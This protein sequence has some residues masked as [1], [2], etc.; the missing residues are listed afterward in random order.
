MECGIW[1]KGCGKKTKT[2]KIPSFFLFEISGTFFSIF[3]KLFYIQ[4]ISG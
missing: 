2:H 3:L 1:E 4:K